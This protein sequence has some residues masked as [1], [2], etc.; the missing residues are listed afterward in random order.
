M[1]NKKLGMGLSS[2]LGVKN[3]RITAN[4]DQENKTNEKNLF[5]IPIEK[6]VRDPEQPRKIFNEEKIK[7]LAIS[8]KK[9]GLIQPIILRKQSEEEY[10]IVAG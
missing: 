2:L 1:K 3:Q 5:F 6:I 7:E 9:H 8:I 10:R 4:V